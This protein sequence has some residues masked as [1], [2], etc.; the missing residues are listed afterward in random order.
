MMDLNDKNILARIRAVTE[1]P[2]FEYFKKY[3]EQKIKELEDLQK[4]ESLT[5]LEAK[6]QAIAIIKNTL[7][8]LK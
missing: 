7:L 3:V 4:I 6:K 2:D 5:D 1:H 8:L